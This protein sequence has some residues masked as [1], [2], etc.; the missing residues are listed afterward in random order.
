[1]DKRGV[2][3]QDKAR[4]A[5]R[6]EMDFA[7]GQGL[8]N[9]QQSRLETYRDQVRK[10][11]EPLL[12]THRKQTEEVLTRQK[13][14]L[15]AAA[16]IGTEER[17]RV[18]DENEIEYDE[19]IAGQRKDI[20]QVIENYNRDNFIGSGK[21]EK[22][23]AKRRQIDFATGQG[24]EDQRQSGQETYADRVRKYL[25]PL[26][27]THRKQTEVVIT[28]HSERLEAAGIGTEARELVK[29]ENR[30]EFDEMITGQRKDIRLEIEKYNTQ[31]GVQG[32]IRSGSEIVRSQEEG[33]HAISNQTQEMS[34]GDSAFETLL[35][36][37]LA[38]RDDNA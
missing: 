4:P 25:E 10:H 28:R 22:R 7:T 33:T 18:K 6:K 38:T 23:P 34:H 16:G 3:S 17:N 9:R 12:E 20:R 26:L 32:G 27:E 21:N 36:D 14:K 8:E 35:D 13:Q 37:I 29:N 2:K 24:L 30:V 5:K 19:M 15:E 31:H 11:L 1:M